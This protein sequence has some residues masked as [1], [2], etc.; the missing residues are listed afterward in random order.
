M[1][2]LIGIPVTLAF[3]EVVYTAEIVLKRD[4]LRIAVLCGNV[5]K[6]LCLRKIVSANG[7]NIGLQ[8]ICRVLIS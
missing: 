3:K 5:S 1:T 2:I 6:S 4:S 7:C 8:G